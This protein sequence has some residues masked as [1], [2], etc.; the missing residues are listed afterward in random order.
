MSAHERPTSY[1]ELV[2]VM[3]CLPMLVRE[4]RR[5]RGLSLRAAAKDA[6]VGFNTLTRFEQGDDVVLSNAVALL[7]WVAA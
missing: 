2:R 7:R 1:G 3:E 6:G 4:T 5:R